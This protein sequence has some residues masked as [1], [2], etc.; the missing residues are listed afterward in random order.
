M[1]RWGI[2]SVALALVLAGCSSSPEASR[3]TRKIEP[4]PAVFRVKFATSKGGF[5]VEVNR[6]WTPFGADRFYDLVKQGFYDD[7]RFFRVV[8]RFI[9][10]FGINKDPAV[11][12]KW[13]DLMLP[14]DPVKQSNLRG[15]LSYAK[16][17]PNTR[18]TQVFI[19]LADNRR[20]DA[21]GFAPF[22]RVVEGMDVIDQI[23]AGYGE[24]PDQN[25]IQVQGNQ[26]LNEHY[27]R[28][29]FIHTARV[30][31]SGAAKP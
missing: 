21:G 12:A 17:M 27:P 10:Q 20:L 15:T 26:Y 1:N 18:T 9:I 4:A 11:S 30:E 28:L 22:G 8:K 2:A 23:Y 14:D 7:A 31:E 25:R 29:D 24:E 19:N 16:S 3:E 13:R 5:T 6:E